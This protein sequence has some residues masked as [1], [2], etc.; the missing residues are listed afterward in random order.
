MNDEHKQ[1]TGNKA[2]LE[3]R[4]ARC[5]QMLARFHSIADMINQAVGRAREHYAVE[6]PVAAVRQHTLRHAQAMLNLRG[7]RADNLWN[8]NWS[9]N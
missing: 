2:P 5:P 4:M 1:I 6:V 9:K 3:D 8:A 7:A